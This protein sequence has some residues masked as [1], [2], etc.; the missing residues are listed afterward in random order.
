MLESGFAQYIRSIELIKN[1]N[2]PD[3]YPHPERMLE[4]L[5]EN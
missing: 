3:Q 5:M 1:D 4:I 2:M